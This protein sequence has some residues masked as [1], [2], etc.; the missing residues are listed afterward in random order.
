MSKHELRARVFTAAVAIATAGAA[1][2]A[3]AAPWEASH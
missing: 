1:V 3:L 2:Y